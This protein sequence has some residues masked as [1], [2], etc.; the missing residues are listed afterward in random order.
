MW[1]GLLIVSGF[2]LAAVLISLWRVERKRV[3][4]QKFEKRRGG[5]VPRK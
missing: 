4:Q 1:L 2:I 5:P 3:E